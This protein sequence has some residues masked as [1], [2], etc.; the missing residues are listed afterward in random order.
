MSCERTRTWF[1]EGQPA[2]M[3][4]HLA[5]LATCAGC[6][7]LLERYDAVVELTRETTAWEPTAEAEARFLQALR[8]R[9]ARR[10]PLVVAGLF[11][12]SAAAAAWG[13]FSTVPTAGEPVVAVPAVEAPLPPGP[14]PEPEPEPE[15]VEE[16]APVVPS[17]QAP[18]PESEGDP[19][20][21]EEQ[22]PAPTLD[23]ARARLAVGDDAGA[24]AILLPWPEGEWRR[25]A[26]LG[27]A[28]QLQ[29]EHGLAVQ[30]YRDAI[31]RGAPGDGVWLDLAA[32]QGRTAPEEAVATWLAY[33]QVHPRGG[34]ERRF[35]LALARQL[36]PLEPE[37]AEEQ[38]RTLLD[39]QPGDAEALTEL[40]A[41]LL[42]QSRWQD[43]EEVLGPYRDHPGAVGELALV[44]LMRAAIG[45]EDLDGVVA[46]VEMWRQRFPEGGR[47]AEVARV[48]QALPPK[49][50]RRLG[51]EGREREP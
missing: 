25:D 27:D 16:L 51:T 14:E 36:A 31:A 22:A 34:A 6:R 43:A 11:A 24:L 8:P 28:W 21:R 30:A 1:S 20:L 17:A 10:W 46:L 26:L 37:R 49:I 38:L 50:R 44:G 19:V 9:R 4:P 40:A 41:L 45:H 39:H 47:A 35:R 13:T 42:A 32:L 48:V 33:L 7:Q 23:D 12:A 15:P 3:A 29:G 2:P 18:E 5:H